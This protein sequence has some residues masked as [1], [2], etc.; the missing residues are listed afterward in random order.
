MPRGDVSRPRQ[1]LATAATESIQL[2]NP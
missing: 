1:L 2:E